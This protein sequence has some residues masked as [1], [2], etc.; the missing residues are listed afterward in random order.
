M[1]EA[2]EVTLRID[3]PPIHLFAGATSPSPRE[4]A[5]R[6]VD[7]LLSVVAEA[8]GLPVPSVAWEAVAKP[9]R[10]G[11]S[12]RLRLSPLQFARFFVARRAAGGA[13]VHRLKWSDPR[14]V[15]VP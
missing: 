11:H 1:A 12:V 13:A 2:F 9:L 4:A 6:Y 8:S 15:Q 7:D 10:G 5:D 3:L 14:E